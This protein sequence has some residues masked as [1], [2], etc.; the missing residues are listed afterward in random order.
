MNSKNSMRA[1]CVACKK[2]T[3]NKNPNVFRTINDRIVLKSNRSVCGNK[4]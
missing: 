4:K 1:Y 3:E 2:D